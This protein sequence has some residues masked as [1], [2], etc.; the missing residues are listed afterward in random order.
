MVS[1]PTAGPARAVVGTI[2]APEMLVP[3]L[4]ALLAASTSRPA[5][6]QACAMQPQLPALAAFHKWLA[7]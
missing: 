5:E 4:S 2:H 3:E 7:S 1:L 6:K